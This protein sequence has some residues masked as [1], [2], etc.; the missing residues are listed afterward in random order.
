MW[1]VE[2]IPDLLNLSDEGRRHLALASYSPP[3]RG[4]SCPVWQV[5]Q[6]CLSAANPARQHWQTCSALLDSVS[7]FPEALWGS[8][9]P[10]AD[11]LGDL[12]CDWSTPQCFSPALNSLSLSLPAAS[13]WH[14]PG[15]LL[16]RSA[17]QNGSCVLWEGMI[18]P[19][20]S[21]PREISSLWGFCKKMKVSGKSPSRHLSE[22]W[23]RS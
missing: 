2:N 9:L 7:S 17:K 12:G 18:Y 16:G 3:L 6:A 13:S 20:S 11:V 5:C 19:S 4:T 22:W 1:R 8:V 23:G 21:N 10:C 15:S 14:F